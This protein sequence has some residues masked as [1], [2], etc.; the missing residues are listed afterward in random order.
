[1]WVNAIDC[2]STVRICS[3]YCCHMTGGFLPCDFV[4]LGRETRNT[5]L[6]SLLLYHQLLAFSTMLSLYFMT[7]WRTSKSLLYDVKSGSELRFIRSILKLVVYLFIYFSPFGHF[8]AFQGSIP[9]ASGPSMIMSIYFL[10]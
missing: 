7:T 6:P 1:M 9:G 5:E 8:A 10:I 4:E 3:P 2:L